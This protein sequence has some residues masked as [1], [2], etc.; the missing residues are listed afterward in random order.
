VLLIL[1]AGAFIAFRYL[2]VD[3]SY[4]VGVNDAGMVTV[5][6]GLPGE[7]AGMSFQSEE[8]V[9][10]LAIDDVPE[11]LRE[12][13]EEGIEADSLVKAEERVADLEAR[14][15]DEEFTKKPENK[16]GDGGGQKDGNG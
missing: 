16:N 8:Q 3:R 2:V 12:N 11:F 15:Q 1:G 6:K 13:V 7:V 5:Y 10:D 9:T 4:F 14:A